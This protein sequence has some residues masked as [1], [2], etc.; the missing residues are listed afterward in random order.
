MWIAFDRL[1]P[2]RTFFW[3]SFGLLTLLALA[4]AATIL[5]GG[6]PAKD[7]FSADCWLCW[8]ELVTPVGVLMLRRARPAWKQP[9]N[10]LAL[11][12]L[13]AGVVALQVWETSRII[14]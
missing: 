3:I 14:C 2:T 12:S 13:M 10:E 5:M 1:S 6:M 8:V 11:A 9:K 4:L 7:L